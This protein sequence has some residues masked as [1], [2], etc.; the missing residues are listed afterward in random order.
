MAVKAVQG[1]VTRHAICTLLPLLVNHRDAV[2]GV[3]HANAAGFGRPVA[4]AIANDVIDLGLAKHFI[5]R[6]T[7]LVHAIRKNGIPHRLARAHAGLQP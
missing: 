7:Q 4:R 5:G 3:G 1:H 6:D 2:P